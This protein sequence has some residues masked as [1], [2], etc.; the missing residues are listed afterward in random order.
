MNPQE[1]EL[2]EMET[3]LFCLEADIQMGRVPQD[4]RRAMYPWEI[5]A[6][7]NFLAIEEEEGDHTAEIAALLLLYRSRAIAAITAGVAIGSTD[8]NG[9]VDEL[10]LLAVALTSS[11]PM[12]KILRESQAEYRAALAKAHQRAGQQVAREAGSVGVEIPPTAESRDTAVVLDR[13]A[14]RLATMPMAD[15]VRAM[16]EAAVQSPADMARDDVLKLIEAEGNRLSAKSLDDYAAQ[17][18]STATGTARLDAIAGALGVG[19]EP[20][21]YASELLDKNTCRPCYSVDGKR[22]DTLDAMR[23]DYPA[24]IYRACEGGMRCRGKPIAVWLPDR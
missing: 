24:G 18:V 21:Y 6:G 23:A 7:V 19:V 20:Q 5:A 22:Y 11:E 4:A 9:I 1:L 17:A 8:T 15:L 12:T 14:T 10:M 3:E 16:Q 2:T 13:Q